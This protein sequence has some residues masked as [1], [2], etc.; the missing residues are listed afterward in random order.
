MNISAFFTQVFLWM[1]VGLGLTAGVAWYIAQN[2]AIFVSLMTT[3]FLLMVLLFIQ[4]GLIFW[5]SSQIMRLSFGAAL[6]MFLV[7]AFLNGIVFSSIFFTYQLGSI[8][9]TFAIASLMFLV[10]AVFGYVTRMNLTPVG[11]FGYMMLWGLII[12]MLVNWF[13][14]SSALDT[15]ISVIGV[16]L[17][18]ALTAY[19][20]QRLSQ[21]ARSLEDR[22]QEL[23]QVA[24]L[25][26]LML[27]LDFIN[28]F[29][30]LL[31]L[32]GKRRN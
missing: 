23:Y 19:D 11:T 7:Y 28:L 15:A 2:P 3:P 6:S 9:S 5:L 21:L 12:A 20:M 8:F 26:S 31:S 24:L 29:M 10:M 22:D 18:S 30:M 16:I 13:L 32:M 17:F 14:H 1:S 25:G 27:Y 4:L